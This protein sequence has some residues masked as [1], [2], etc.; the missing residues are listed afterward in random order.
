MKKSTVILLSFLFFA[1]V[2][3]ITGYYVYL[4]QDL[5][6]NFDPNDYTTWI[7]WALAGGP[8][9]AWILFSIIISLIPTKEE[10]PKIESEDKD[11][12]KKEEKIEASEEEEKSQVETKQEEVKAEDLYPKEIAVVQLLGLL[13]RE[14]RLIDFLQE[15]IEPYEDAQIGA[16][17]REVHRGCKKA[18]N[19]ALALKPVLD[20]AEGSEVEIEEDFDPTKIRLIGNVH[21][22]PP[23]KGIIRHCG[24]RF[25]KINLPEW[26][27][28]EKTDVLAPAEV[29]IQ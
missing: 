3:I 8:I 9:A 19:D 6:K 11:I 18:L 27:G 7:G 21:G 22:E 24:W 14:G 12:V 4:H 10:S 20:A 16:A 25:T 5:L 2:N 1:A 13:Q 26:T 28:K 17:V 23:F 15:D 29:E